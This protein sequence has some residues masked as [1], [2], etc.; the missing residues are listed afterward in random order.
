[1]L[2]LR[3][4]LSIH[5]RNLRHSS[6]AAGEIYSSENFFSSVRPLPALL[7]ARRTEHLLAADEPYD[8]IKVGFNLLGAC[9]P[10]QDGS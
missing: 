2:S 6:E 10:A 4:L 9:L 1:M 5:F 7:L 3:H 8:P